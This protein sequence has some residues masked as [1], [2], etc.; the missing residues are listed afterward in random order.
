MWVERC[1]NAPPTTQKACPGELSTVQGRYSPG[2][3]ASV[4]AN[5]HVVAAS[6]LAS[7]MFAQPSLSQRAV[8]AE[9]WR[10]G[11]QMERFLYLNVTP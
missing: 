9:R 11:L 3:Q 8:S 5:L 6:K 10:E 7:N 1:V 4:S 2:R